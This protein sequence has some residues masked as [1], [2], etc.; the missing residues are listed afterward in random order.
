MTAPSPILNDVDTGR[1]TGGDVVWFPLMWDLTGRSV[2]V[3]GGG[4]AA[5]EKVNLLVAARAEVTVIAS[6]VTDTLGDFAAKGVVKR[7]RRDFTT[8][9]LTG[10]A[11]VI[12]ATD[13]EGASSV[14]YAEAESLGLPINAVDDPARCSVIFPAV[15]RDGPLV[16]AVSTSGAA[17]A[18]AVR[19]R[20][21]I[22][23]MTGGYG[24]WLQLLAGFRTQ[25]RSRFATFGERRD[26]WYQIA[27]TATAFDAARS[28]DDQ[29]A[30]RFVQDV[31]DGFPRS[32][33]S[34]ASPVVVR[35][36]AGAS[37]IVQQAEQRI[38]E[39]LEVATAPVVTCSMQLGGLVLL[40]LVRRLDPD[41]R[42][43]FVDTGYH[44]PETLAFR[45][46]V[47][48]EWD[49]N[50]TI[51]SP[52]LN[53]ADHESQLGRLYNTDPAQCCALRKVGPT[54]TVLE[55]HDLWF[56][57]VRRSQGASRVDL[58]IS[59]DHRLSSGKTIHKLHPLVDWTW[60]DVEAYADRHD[61]PRHPLYEQGYSSIGC[62]PCTTPTF[63]VADE[64]TG[65]WDGTEMNECGLHLF[66]DTGEVR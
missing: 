36:T 45:D 3:V 63:G 30:G 61:I 2:V 35:S 8:G 56:A 59:L 7:V 6:K 11:L 18:V 5:E 43:V 10:A 57:A 19:L 46:R 16:V 21:R 52:E 58:P 47:A 42:V 29:T 15:H 41:V 44:F 33:G 23:R 27:D 31:I 49:L 17:P 20:D 48:A 60:V 51:A 66:S 38:S 65:R 32:T 28:G 26:V 24:R 53:V 37:G 12:A 50:L 54:E 13:D 55:E 9:D 25:I 62:A 1:S 34:S 4:G 22:A 39:A 40:D 64:R 14:V